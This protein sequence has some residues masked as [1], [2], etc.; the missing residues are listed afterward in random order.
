MN[1]G[2]EVFCLRIVSSGELLLFIY[3]SFNETVSW[4]DYIA[5]NGRMINEINEEKCGKK[6]PWP[7]LRY[8]HG[9]FLERTSEL[10]VFHLRFELG[11]SRIQ[12]RNIVA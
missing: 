11:I 6:M 3:G 10:S 2:S 5:W 7:N 9:D 1:T 12:V 8:H 4:S